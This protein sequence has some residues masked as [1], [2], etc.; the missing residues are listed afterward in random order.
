MKNEGILSTHLKYFE[1]CP[2]KTKIKTLNLS[3]NKITDIAIILN[4]CVN[5]ENLILA[6]N[7]IINIRIKKSLKNLIKLIVPTNKI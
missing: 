2:E 1:K 5:V 4:E 3:N 7:F 6:K